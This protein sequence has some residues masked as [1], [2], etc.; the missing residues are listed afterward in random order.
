MAY[1]NCAKEVISLLKEES[2][3][4]HWEH[5]KEDTSIIF[6]AL[7]HNVACKSLLLNTSICCQVSMEVFKGLTI[8][9]YIVPLLDID[10]NPVYRHFNEY[11]KDEEECEIEAE[12]GNF[13]FNLP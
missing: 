4:K 13:K 3:N 11:G 5:N 8:P 7:L 9:N 2:P 6:N 12:T 10:I 1:Q